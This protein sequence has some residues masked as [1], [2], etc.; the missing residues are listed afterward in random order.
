M[1]EECCQNAGPW[2]HV[3]EGGEGGRGLGG[4]TGKGGQR[5]RSERCGTRPSV[6]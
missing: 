6:Q 1:T 3:C 4:E 2:G 5:N